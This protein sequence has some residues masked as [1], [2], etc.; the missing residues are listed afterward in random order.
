MHKKMF[1]RF[2]NIILSASLFFLTSALY[3]QSVV[4]DVIV[5]DGGFQTSSAG[6]I[7]YSLGEPISETVANGTNILTQG[8]QQPIVF[9]TVNVSEFADEGSIVAF[10]N[11]VNDFIILDFSKLILG[12]YSITIYSLDGK[13]IYLRDLLINSDL[14]QQKISMENLSAG[15]YLFKL[16]EN[17]G[18][19]TKE[20]K[21]IK[22][23]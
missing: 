8:F 4:P 23:K 5:S 20:F 2:S 16:A 3:S 12:N 11:P 10:P 9:A 1:N 15:I 13:Q 19:S 18:L 7:S 21:I 14:I 17:T 22:Q 6:S